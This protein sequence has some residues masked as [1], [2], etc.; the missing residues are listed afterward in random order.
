MATV[1][2]MAQGIRDINDETN[3]LSERV[4]RLIDQINA[5]GMSAVDEDAALAELVFLRD[6]LKGIAVSPEN[7]V[8]LTPTPPTP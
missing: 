2:Q 8:P 6:R 1:E 3:L 7:P 5:G 4:Q